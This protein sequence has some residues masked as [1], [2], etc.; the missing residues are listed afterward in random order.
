MRNE[1][2]NQP[3]SLGSRKY[4]S[5]P[6]RRLR[7]AR[8]VSS[9]QVGRLPHPSRET[10]SKEP[11]KYLTRSLCWLESVDCILLTLQIYYTGQDRFQVWDDGL[12]QIYVRCFEKGSHPRLAAIRPSIVGLALLQSHA[13]QWYSHIRFAGGQDGPVLVA[14]HCGCGRRRRDRTEYEFAG[15][16]GHHLV[17]SVDGLCVV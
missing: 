12:L 1:L 10:S 6:M 11:P 15:S 5:V 16:A 17:L 14:R 7:S 2:E 9:T 4:T 13:S 8:N 3:T